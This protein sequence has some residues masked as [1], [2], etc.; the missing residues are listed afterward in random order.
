M[1]EGTHVSAYVEDTLLAWMQLYPAQPP[2]ADL[3]Q[4]CDGR[5]LL[6]LLETLPH[7]KLVSPL[8]ELGEEAGL[9]SRVAT[10]KTITKSLIHYHQQHLLRDV[11][12]FAINYVELCMG[13]R[14]ELFRLITILFSALC[15]QSASRAALEEQ[16][17][18][19]SEDKYEIIKIMID[20]SMGLGQECGSC[21]SRSWRLS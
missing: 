1:E 7:F 10:M 9:A 3:N 4:V 12:E 20:N 18:R 15:S 6:S 21:S 5:F 14:K 16:I 8:S 11:S 19:L 13:N 2:L 17:S